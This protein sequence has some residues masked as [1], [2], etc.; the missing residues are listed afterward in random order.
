MESISNVLIYDIFVSPAASY[1]A[2]LTLDRTY[3]PGLDDP[4]SP[5]YISLKNDV[6]NVVR[7]IKLQNLDNLCAWKHP[8]DIAV[9]DLQYWNSFH[10]QLN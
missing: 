3:D 9:A 7:G 2:S 8:G 1:E 4:S 6:E 5:A 10:R